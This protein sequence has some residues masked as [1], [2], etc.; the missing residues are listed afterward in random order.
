MANGTWKIARGRNSGQW[1]L[2]VF[3]VLALI[4]LLL[5]RAQPA[6]FNRA[7][8]YFTDWSSP[9][10][11]AARVPVDVLVNWVEGAGNIFTVYADNTRLKAENA[12]LRQWQ[13]AALVLEERVKRYQL[14]L[15]AVPDPAIASV[16]ARVI[17]RES[18][19]FLNTLILDAGRRQGVKPGEAVV[20]AQG[21]IGRILVA[22]ERTSWVILLT[23][24]NSR[25]PVTIE[26]GHIQAML[27]GDN[28]LSPTLEVSG[29][30]VQLKQGEP[31]LT[32][33]DGGLLPGGLPI[34]MVWWDGQE[35]RAA[36]LADGAN[37][38]D[39][40][41]LDLKLPPEQM[42]ALSPKDLP[43]AAAGLPPMAPPPPKSAS[44]SV[45]PVQ[46][47]QATN[48]ITGGRTGPAPIADSSAAGNVL[49]K[50]APAVGPRPRPAQASAPPPATPRAD[51]QGN[52]PDELDR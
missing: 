51:T 19:P 28:T 1:P 17:G 45:S 30:G 27:A 8:T 4:V 15:N 20:D 52:P 12:R 33:G 47:G 49:P 10:L 41:I 40:R 6:L 16:T 31:I 37:S 32:S 43:V 18:R 25:I 2:A 21:M 36:L 35:F 39:V 9:V 44:A 14:L 42:P 13:N 34:G 29:Q 5:G 23:D 7:R 3:G 11:E 22:G 26:P 48:S 50:T 38:D 24:L 46:P